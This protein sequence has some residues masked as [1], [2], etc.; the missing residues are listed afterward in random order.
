MKIR[1]SPAG[2]WED[3]DEWERRT[4]DEIIANAPEDDIAI[5][6]VP[7][8]VEDVDQWLQDNQDKW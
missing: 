4:M 3:Q 1:V 6:D 5:L 7:D 8:D 2:F